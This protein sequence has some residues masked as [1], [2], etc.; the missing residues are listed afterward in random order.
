MPSPP[1]LFLPF[2]SPYP[3]SPPSYPTSFLLALQ[4]QGRW[5]KIGKRR[6]LEDESYGWPREL[7]HIV[8]TNPLGK[9]PSYGVRCI[10]I[11]LFV[12][13]VSKRFIQYLERERM[14]FIF[15]KIQGLVIWLTVLLWKNMEQI[16]F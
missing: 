1:P 15:Y 4:G 11:F 9:A 5:F 7:C 6:N 8:G 2:P 14:V 12:F 13:M 16:D 3:S 10:I